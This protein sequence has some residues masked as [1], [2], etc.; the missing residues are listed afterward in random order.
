MIKAKYMKWQSDTLRET[1]L[2]PYE[3]GQSGLADLRRNIVISV[4]SFA[5]LMTLAL[6][7][8][9]RLTGQFY[10]DVSQGVSLTIFIGLLISFYATF[11]FFDKSSE[12][13]MKSGLY[14]RI[15]VDDKLQDE[16]EIAQKHKAQSKSFEWVMWGGLGAFVLWLGLRVVEGLSGWTLLVMPSF[17][18]SLVIAI[19]AL[20][21][22]SLLPLIYTSYTVAPINDDDIAELVAER[23]N[24]EIK[25]TTPIDLLT[26]PLTK[27]QKWVKRFW[28]VSPYILG[29][30]VGVWLVS[31]GNAGFLYDI[32]YDIGRWF[33]KLMKG[34]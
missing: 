2:N 27:R 21:T 29:G 10:P 18:V 22:L 5:I 9:R 32:G 23:A 20:Y 14:W 19:T 31:S 7:F 24:D 12:V 28:A 33:G 26:A 17:G 1:P 30:F 3:L 4:V 13:L 11:K 8:I 6:F 16:W 25:D 15:S 34:G